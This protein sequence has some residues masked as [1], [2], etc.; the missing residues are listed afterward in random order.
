MYTGGTGLG[1]KSLSLI[2]AYG[3]VIAEENSI[4]AVQVEYLRQWD[5]GQFTFLGLYGSQKGNKEWKKLNKAGEDRIYKPFPDE[6]YYEDRLG[7][8]KP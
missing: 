5:W 3:D 2:K 7:Q 8:R 1:I 4:P 6:K